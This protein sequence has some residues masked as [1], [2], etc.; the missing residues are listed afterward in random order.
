MVDLSGAD[1]S[2]I[3][4]PPSLVDRAKAMILTPKDEW[5]K[6]ALETTPQ[7]DIL[8]SY[9]LPLAA[10]GPVASLI[11]GQVFGYGAFGFS[12]RPPL[13][14]ALISAALAY[15]L[16]I[17]GVF[18]LSLIVDALA[19]KFDGQGNKLAAFKLVAYSYTAAW[20]AGIF[21]LIPSLAFFGLLGIYSFYVLYTGVTPLMKVPES[22]A[23]GYLAVTI[24]SAIVV[25]AIVGVV[26]GRTTAAFIGNPLTAS[27]DQVSGKLTVPGG[28]SVDLGKLQQATKQ[29]EAAANG[30]SPPVAPD[31]M[32]ALLPETI[33]S[34]QRTAT[35][36]VGAGAMGSTAQ[37]TYTSGDKSFT[38]RIA[39]MSALGALSGLGAAMGVEQSK[40][41]ANS[42]ERTTTVN[43]Q[44][45]TEAWNKTTNSGKFGT[46]VNNRFMIEAEGSAGSIDELKQAVGSIDHDDLVDLVG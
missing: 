21:G 41:D 22:K 28:G 17:L 7:G 2:G 37:G 36:G 20:L 3:D 25:Y 1:L 13:I 33:G 46:T 6:I 34:Y 35:E 42:Y 30:K 4:R 27:N 16:S 11:G 40:E 9:V 29:M 32:K 26:V 43:G 39:D 31:R 12:Y 44:I 24:I 15:G 23:G 5:A 45:Q 19:P 10:I 18:I 8:K 38:L 14:G